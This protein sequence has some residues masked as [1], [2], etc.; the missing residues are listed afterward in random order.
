MQK[1][2]RYFQGLTMLETI[3]MVLKYMS[4]VSGMFKNMML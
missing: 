3:E 4:I 2:L 1:R